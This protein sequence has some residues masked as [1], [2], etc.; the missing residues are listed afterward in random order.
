MVTFIYK[1]R[2]V[3][4]MKCDVIVTKV[5]NWNKH[6][7]SK[8]IKHK[9][10]WISGPLFLQNSF[11]SHRLFLIRSHFIISLCRKTENSSLTFSCDYMSGPAVER[12]LLRGANR[13]ELSRAEK[14]LAAGLP[15]LPGP[16]VTD[17]T[18]FPHSMCVCNSF[19]FFQAVCAPNCSPT[20]TRSCCASVWVNIVSAW[21]VT[22][23]SASDWLRSAVSHITSCWLT[24]VFNRVTCCVLMCSCVCHL[25]KRR[26]P[27]SDNSQTDWGDLPASH[28]IRSEPE[29]QTHSH[30]STFSSGSLYQT[31]T[32]GQQ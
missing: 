30:F 16:R 20:R 5:S 12:V 23:T 24:P 22:S 31:F 4:I 10:L 27:D 32:W 11:S 25:Q 8:L 17:T 13:P 19:S 15:V 26:G 18:V 29:P 21:Q 2:S 7:T 9:V 3:N 1:K 14:L 28:Q 6:N